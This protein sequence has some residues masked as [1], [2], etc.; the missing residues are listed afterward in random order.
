MRFKNNILDA[1]F[2]STK[3]VVNLYFFYS[4]MY[5]T[6]MAIMALFTFTLGFQLLLIQEQTGNLMHVYNLPVQ[7]NFRVI[8]VIFSF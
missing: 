2:D 4:G 5:K 8:Q 3:F 6:V 7:E 1:G